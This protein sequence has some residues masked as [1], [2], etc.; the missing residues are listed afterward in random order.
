MWPNRLWPTGAAS[1]KRSNGRDQNV[2]SSPPRL[3]CHSTSPPESTSRETAETKEATARPQ[4]V[5]RPDAVELLLPL[6]RLFPA[7][8]TRGARWSGKANEVVNFGHFGPG[9]SI[10]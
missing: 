5:S 4:R 10:S 3:L 6:F 7:T 8:L 9:R 1:L 2:Q